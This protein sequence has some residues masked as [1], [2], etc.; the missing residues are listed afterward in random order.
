METEAA[1][2]ARQDEQAVNAVRRGDTERYRELVE[3]Y[4]RRVYAVAWSRLGDVALAEEAT[5]EAFIRAYRRLWLVG[6][7]AKFAGWIATIARNTAINLGL[8]HRRELDKCE[9]WALEC[10]PEENAADEVAELCPPEMLRQALAEL[11][12]AHR[13]CLVLFYLEGKSG[14]EAAVVL[15]ISEAALRVRLHRAR[16]AMRERLEEKL[17]GSLEQLRPTKTL[18]PAV[19]ATILASSPAKLVG[20]G[21]GAKILYYL[22][23]LKFFFLFMWAMMVLPNLLLSLVTMRWER[24]RA[25]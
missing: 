24:A 3:R 7:G 9:R 19:M 6:D 14:A 2:L 15:G 5:Q 25:D 20:S 18:V 4:E 23:P 1:N 10:M 11:P 13:E 16:A 12:A 17:E 22:L 21:V 8:R